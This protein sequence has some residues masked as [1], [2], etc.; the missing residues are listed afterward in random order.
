V[1]DPRIATGARV[2]VA[3]ALNVCGATDIGRQRT[4]NEDRFHV[5]SD[6]SVLA[7]A[8]GLGGLPAGEVASAI[9]ITAAIAVLDGHA[10]GC[11]DE[12]AAIEMLGDVFRSA[13]RAIHADAMREPSHRGMATTLVAAIVAGSTMYLSHVG[14]VR[15]Y[16]LGKRGLERL[17]DDHTTAWELV[18]AGVLTEQ[19]ARIHPYRNAL[20]RVLGLHERVDPSFRAVP[21]SPG[22][23]VLLCSDGL[24]EPVTAPDI[25]AVL[26]AQDLD[27]ELRVARLLDRALD[28]GG[29]DNVTVATYV[30]AG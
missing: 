9:A 8:D 14:D 18:E 24:W 6:G 19:E 20:T 5:A 1:T 16:R 26:A 21:L 30:H 11:C 2:V 4:S 25:A 10:A 29:P 22:D 12:V 17:T 15:A 27:L 23:V 28:A 7:V 3:P 13:N